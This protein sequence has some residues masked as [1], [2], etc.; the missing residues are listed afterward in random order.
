MNWINAEDEK[1]PFR[2]HSQDGATERVM[3]WVEK[4]YY[5]HLYFGHYEYTEDGSDWEVDGLHY[6]RRE[7]WKVTHW[8]KEPEKPVQKMDKPKFRGVG[9]RPP[10]YKGNWR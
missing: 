3:V 7:D 1:P 5:P 2:P 6:L 8:A 9:P 10:N 4:N